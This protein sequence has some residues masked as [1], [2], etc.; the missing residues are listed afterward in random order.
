[1]K[2]HIGAIIFAVAY[3]TIQ[4]AVPIWG[5]R[6]SGQSRFSWKMFVRNE[7]IS[8]F[9]VVYKDGSCRSLDELNKATPVAVIINPV[10]EA[11]FIP[12][13]LCRLKG[14]SSV[15]IRQSTVER[16]YPCG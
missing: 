12:P 5:L 2:Q 14:V 3:L 15:I 9:V 6:I 4:V 13:H 1:M 8:N 10:D 7:D 16:L 11:K